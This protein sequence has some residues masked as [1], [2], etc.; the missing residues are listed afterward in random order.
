MEERFTLYPNPASG[1]INLEY[2]GPDIYEVMV[3]ITDLSGK[4]YLSETLSY[5]EMDYKSTIDISTLPRGVY[6]VSFSTSNYRQHTKLMV[7]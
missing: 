5:L 4:S 1:H 6:I 2:A 7:D 3:T